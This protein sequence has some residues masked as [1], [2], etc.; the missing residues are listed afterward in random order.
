MILW[1]ILGMSVVT[2]VPRFAPVFIMDRLELP[3]WGR[4]WLAA[5]PYA[6][7]GALIIPGIFTVIDG[8][9]WAGMAGGAAAVL[10]AWLRAPIMVTV[11]IAIITVL[12]ISHL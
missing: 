1:M 8:K 10:A 11:L 2:L 9:P 5:I 4:R 12:L 7:L 3:P 6:A